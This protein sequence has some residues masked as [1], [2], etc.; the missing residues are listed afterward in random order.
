MSTPLAQRISTSIPQT[1]A[2]RAER[3]RQRIG[4]N[5]Y[6][7]WGEGAEFLDA[8]FGAAPYLGRLAARRPQTLERLAEEPP[9][10]LL[11]EAN[12]TAGLA[13]RDP[14]TAMS[15]LRRAKADM[16]LVTAL[17]DLAGA[18]TLEETV[19]AVSDFADAAVQGA[20]EAAARDSGISADD[21]ENPAPGLF[22][23]TLGKHGQRSLNYSSD[24]DL[25]VMWEPDRIG[26][27][28]H[29]EP[30]RRYTRLTR[31]L[32]AYLNEV[33]ADGY[34]FRVDLRLR[35]DPSSTPAAVN[36][37]MARNYFEALGQNWER[38]AYAKARV[39]AGD[40]PA[41]EQFLKDLDPFVWRR[42]LD[43]EAVDDIRGIARQ[44]Q[45]TRKRSEMIAA[46]HDVKLGR[47]GIREIEFFAQI[48]QLVFGGRRK[49]LRV[50]STLPALALLAREQLISEEDAEAMST[51]YRQ[52]RAIEHRIQMLEDEQSQTVPE[53]ITTRTRL[54][55]LMGEDDI[56]RF[57][58]DLT[59]LLG[60]VHTRFVHQFDDGESLA[61]SVGSLVLTGVEPTPETLQTL[62]QHGFS[63][64]ERVWQRLAGWAAGK[65]RAARTERARA[66]FSK[67]A[68]KLVEGLSQTGDPDVAFTRFA[69]FFEGLPVG[70]QPLSLLVKQPALARELLTILGLAP[71]LAE[72]LARCPTLL[73]VMVDTGFAAPL[74]DDLED[75]YPLR[76]G[77]VDPTDFEEALNQARRIAREERLRIGAQL[78]VG[79]ARASEAGVA[80][81]R[82]A[83]AAT[84]VMAQAAV[85]EVARRHGPAPGRWAVFGLGKHGGR[86]L[87]ADSD[88]DLVVVYDPIREQSDGP[89]PVSAEA[90]FVRFTQRLV[91][92]LSAPTEEGELYQVD[93]ALRPSG[94]AGPVAVRL[95]R[96]KT[97]YESEEAW[98]W[99]RMALTRA[100]VVAADGLGLDAEAALHHAI[101]GAGE[102]DFVRKDA[103][104]MRQRLQRDKPAKS[105]WDLKLRDGGLIEIEFIVQV[106]QLILGEQLST[107]TGEA[108]V[109]LRT[110][111]VLSPD[112]AGLLARAHEDYAAL[113][114]LIR[115]AHGAGFDPE[116]ASE[117]FADRLAKAC[118]ETDLAGV[119]HRLDRHT[120]RVR[121][122]FEKY[123]GG[124][125]Q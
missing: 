21:P 84:E 57:D 15:T 31:K 115:A 41:G 28:G 95:S 16:H 47:G 8:V 108:I 67:F 14:N 125:S 59:A 112:D 19:C 119:Q 48:M 62:T 13:G 9:E 76:F 101:E 30:T 71:R 42:S 114:Q 43:F 53:D 12:E 25:V 38:A 33:T 54:A 52:L 17:A 58:R 64:P 5:A 35:P 75:R 23:L 51:A 104:E 24:I 65:A 66:L 110:R 44:I 20:L 39:C 93:M 121:Q 105:I 118:E 2:A 111:G 82:L 78:L 86:E 122:V 100:R 106:L 63:D 107:N 87:S 98:T 18:F 117:P 91:A 50:A 90:W 72:M 123:V 73:D 34:V 26:S 83:D 70:V 11:T 77:E 74:G 1:D 102:D 120:R 61:T 37:E 113:T 4:S 94:N 40:R 85:R 103:C 32:S 46:G 109:Q 89:K 79:R 10:V 60:D 27:E 3:S 29:S 96:F 81:A 68:P 80:F 7:A 36:A 69:T 55:A 49:A 97:Y 116:T 88:L 92:A 22:V 56:D 124:L 6:S 45:S 99:E